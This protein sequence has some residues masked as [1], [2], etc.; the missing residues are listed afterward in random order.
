MPEEITEVFQHL[1]SPEF[2]GSLVEHLEKFISQNGN[3]VAAIMLEPVQFVG[4]TTPRENYYEGI[5]EVA[6]KHDILIIADECATFARFGSLFASENLGLKP[7]IYNVGKGLSN[8]YEKVA[9][10]LVSEEIKHKIK[11]QNIPEAAK[12]MFG[13]TLDWQ[14]RDV[15]VVNAVLDEIV[16]N[17]LLK[18][19]LENSLS[20]Q[21]KLEM[22]L[23]DEESIIVSGRGG[24]S[25]ITFPDDRIAGLVRRELMRNHNIYSYRSG[26][27]I[28]MLMP[29]V[30]TEENLNNVAEAVLES[31]KRT[32]Q[33]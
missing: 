27:G 6:E 31:H 21:K 14:P 25:T 32:K 19:G 7:D 16:E 30:K 33:K 2:E 15:Y 29:L 13:S 3:V 20:L 26:K 10:V 17:G 12:V 9:A 11:S 5:N 23:E 18:E 28:N 24:W 1:P 22:K 4:A 8:S